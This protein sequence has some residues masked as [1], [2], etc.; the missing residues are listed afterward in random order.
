MQGMRGITEI[1]DE[2]LR[3]TRRWLVHALI[4]YIL[5][6]LA[7][8]FLDVVF[9]VILDPFG[10][11]TRDFTAYSDAMMLGVRSVHRFF[12]ALFIY[13]AITVSLKTVRMVLDPVLRITPIADDLP[14]IGALLVLTELLVLSVVTSAL[15][16]V[17]SL[18]L[19]EAFVHEY[20][21]GVLA[22]CLPITLAA[23]LTVRLVVRVVHHRSPACTITYN[24]FRE[25]GAAGHRIQHTANYGHAVPVRRR[26]NAGGRQHRAGG[27]HRRCGP[28]QPSR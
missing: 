1:S 2:L 3:V 14:F 12:I 22:Y 20:S 18:L 13:A 24:P 9:F 21:L 23:A 10:F 25:E 26:C 5:L 7:I 16:M 8:H 28:K 19:S 6:I 27:N 17:L 4:T 11:S 15:Q